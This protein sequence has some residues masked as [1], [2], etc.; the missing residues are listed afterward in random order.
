METGFAF[1]DTGR[2]GFN[3]KAKSQSNLENIA[4]LMVSSFADY[5]LRI[6]TPTLSLLQKS[7]LSCL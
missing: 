1:D 5:I 7:S 2:S 3:A 6:L 4:A